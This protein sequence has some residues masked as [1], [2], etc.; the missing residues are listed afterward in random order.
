MLGSLAGGDAIE[1]LVALKDLTGKGFENLE[2]RMKKVESTGNSVSFSGFSK[3][4]KGAEADAEK[5]AGEGGGKGGIMGLASSFLSIPGPVGIAAVA[6]GAAVAAGV[7]L[8]P[9]SD[10]VEAQEKAL[11]TAFKDHG[12]SLDALRPKVDDAIKSGEQYGFNADQTRAAITQLTSAGL[13]F[14]Q[15]QAALPHVMDLARSQNVSLDVATQGYTS[16]VYGNARA[17]KQYGII[18]PQVSTSAADVTAK[19]KL[20]DAASQSVTAART[21]LTLAEDKLHA[22]HKATPALLAAV[23]TAQMKLK[24]ATDKQKAAEEA[25]T[26]AKKGGVDVNARLKL[27]NDGLTKAIKDQRGSAT[28]L[29][30]DQAKLSDTVERF[31]TIVG[32]PM[33]TILGLIMQA[34]SVLL[35]VVNNVLDVLESLIGMAAKAISGPLGALGHILG[36]IGGAIGGVT[37]AIGGLFGGH[38]AAGGPVEAGK[39]YVVGERGPELLMAGGPGMVY[40]HG[41]AG[42]GSTV[43][44]THIYLDGRVLADVVDKH[45]GRQRALRGSSLSLA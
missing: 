40:P 5:A 9:I 12:E 19:T 2:G 25:L 33:V 28:S 7:A 3:G 4:A 30:V 26:L 18:L 20:L 27:V 43:V 22:A 29:Q 13:N 14:Q 10:K 23:Q 36:G 8:I 24:D 31:A 1:I 37:G 38:H 42:G 35:D 44:H 16:S 17:L 34:F 15:V 39:F 6:L 11:A 21:K 41:A 45:L 32:P